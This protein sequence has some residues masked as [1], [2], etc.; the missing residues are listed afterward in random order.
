MRKG[1]RYLL[2]ALPAALV[3]GAG[4]AVWA[5]E[6]PA[7]APAAKPAAAVPPEV[8]QKAKTYKGSAVPPS[9]LQ[10]MADGHWTPYSPPEKPAEGGEVYTIQQGDTL[11]GLAQQKLGTWLLWPQIWDQN[12]Y[13]KD[14]HWIYPGDPLLIAKPAV[15]SEE[16][17]IAAQPVQ[18]MAEEGG[19]PS[20]AAGERW[21][22]DEEAPVPPVNAADV[23]CSGYITK[24]WRRPHLTVLSSVS[25]EKESLAQGD[26]VY[27]NE[28]SAEGIESG[29][30]FAILWEGPLIHH[31]KTGKTI[32]RWIRRAGQAKILAVQEHTSIAQITQS[33]DEI[34]YGAVMVP[35][36][37]IPVPW[38][39]KPAEAIPLQLPPSSKPL[40]HIVW[41]QDRLEGMGQ[42]SIVYVNLG[43]R[44]QVIPG[45]KLW[46]FQYPAEQ[47]TLVDSTHD[48]FRQQ[49]V[50]VNIKDL[51]RDQKVGKYKPEKEESAL[52]AEA[53]QASTE[54]APGE[55]PPSWENEGVSG[56]RSYIGEGVVLTTE[57][58][59]ACVKILLSSK[60]ISMGDWVQ[61]E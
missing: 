10:R 9:S 6:S 60:E 19:Q 50:D 30:T 45:D 25:A 42:N 29:M 14:A 44:N 33:C 52:Q 2:P 16:G 17:P 11:S 4:L 23:Y 20:A 56:I 24:N 39:I 46:I 35:F 61:V 51:F 21:Q 34:R 26:V 22:I 55:E 59:T 12:P 36:R 40:G 15:V 5:Q 3:L 37:A 28:G 58:D 54:A 1:M 27:V 38:D 41:T 49:K 31:P 8:E 18:E 32:G 13:I 53:A 7:Q 48:L 57:A 43:S 47:G